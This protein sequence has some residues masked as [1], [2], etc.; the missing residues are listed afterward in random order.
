[1]KLFY[2]NKLSD[3]INQFADSASKVMSR[4]KA[5]VS[6]L[7]FNGRHSREPLLTLTRIMTLT[8]DSA[9]ECEFIFL[10]IRRETSYDNLT[11]SPFPLVNRASF[12][13][14]LPLHVLTKSLKG[15][16]IS[17]LLVCMTCAQMTCEG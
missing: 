3:A 6:F 10:A 8:R 12:V 14:A 9:T 5:K 4:C 2:L 16:G 1:M 13:Y 15:T 11:M 17:V 7:R